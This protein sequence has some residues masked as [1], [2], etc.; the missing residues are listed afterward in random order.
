MEAQ[1]ERTR[2]LVRRMSSLC[3]WLTPAGIGFVH[4]FSHRRLAC[5]FGGT[6]AAERFFAAGTMPSHELLTRF[7]GELFVADR[8]ALSGEDYARTLRSWLRRLD[9]RAAEALAILRRGRSERDARTLL[10]TWRLF[11]LSTAEMWGWRGGDEWMLSRYLLERERRGGSGKK[12]L[13]RAT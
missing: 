5:R 11:L 10:G 8:W 2:E 9:E 13:V 3:E 6:W 12:P 7:D 4:A 1:E